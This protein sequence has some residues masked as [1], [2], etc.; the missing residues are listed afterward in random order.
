MKEQNLHAMVYET[1]YKCLM[2]TTT[3]FSSAA[4]FLVGIVFLFN[5]E[6]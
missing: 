2:A 1:V 3:V 6:N 5:S 4:D